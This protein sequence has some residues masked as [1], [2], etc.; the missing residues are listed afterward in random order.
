MMFNCNVVND[1]LPLY[2]EDI[3][4][5]DSKAAMEAH[6]QG[7]A[8]CREKL[9]RMKN[10]GV[11][12]RVKKQESTFAIAAYTK[13]VKRHRIRVGLAAAFMSV[14]AAF[15]SVPATFVYSKK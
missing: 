1:L 4:S 11:I 6:L 9:V 3:C 10:D 2:L 14:L 13:K 15:R 12:P 8:V 7:C 5:Q